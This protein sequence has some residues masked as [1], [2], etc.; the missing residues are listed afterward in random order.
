MKCFSLGVRGRVN[1][2]EDII[3]LKFFK[4]LAWEIWGQNRLSVV[5]FA[6]IF[7][8][9]A[10]LLN[11]LVMNFPGLDIKQ[12]TINN[13][14]AVTCLIF[15]GI[16]FS[17]TETSSKS[18][19]TGFPQHL[20]L[21]PMPT[22]Q[23]LLTPMLLGV[24]ILTLYGLVW[25]N[26]I[27]PIQLSAF[28]QTAVLL[29]LACILIW[30]QF[31]NWVFSK[32]AVKAISSLLICII[33][34]GMFGMSALDF[35]SYSHAKLIGIIG[36]LIIFLSGV[37]GALYYVD[38]CR[39]GNEDAGID[40]L[41]EMIPSIGGHRAFKSK[42]AAQFW[43]ESKFFGWIFPLFTF[44]ISS[45]LYFASGAKQIIL[46]FSSYYSVAF[47]LGLA[48]ATPF[49]GAKTFQMS[50]SVGILPLS[51]GELASSKLK[52]GLYSIVLSSVILFVSLY[53]VLFWGNYSTQFLPFW[54]RIIAEVGILNG[55]FGVIY[56]TLNG[57]ALAWV[58]FGV[59]LAVCMSN[60][61]IIRKI[62]AI[63]GVVVIFLVV[64]I[65]LLS[66]I[67]PSVKLFV[68][69]VTIYVL[70]LFFVLTIVVAVLIARHSNKVL[71]PVRFSLIV[72]LSFFI[73]ALISAFLWDLSLESHII[74]YCLLLTSFLLVV[75]FIVFITAPLSVA[76]NRHQD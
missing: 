44:A 1:P 21:L 55:I 42:N 65:I 66:N 6:F 70:G 20:F 72:F 16:T 61:K 48:L 33:F 27:L 3:S 54:Y 45:F 76:M 5:L 24:M 17:Y 49:F 23:L 10:Y 28:E 73:L 37:I 32:N 47:A 50:P 30:L 51:D 9:M 29:A 63:S 39:M 22:W 38:A 43:Y 59:P 7:P 31:I 67:Y 4:I 46:V 68:D 75:S 11:L 41:G 40:V 64:S 8:A 69:S 52:V 14:L 13:N 62:A 12:S 57:I 2:Q 26:L 25:I 56:L 36:I 18:V 74:A 19:K 53:S 15:I 35:F 34:V 60:K 71:K 58:L